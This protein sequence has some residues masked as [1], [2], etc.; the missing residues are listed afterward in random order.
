M[1][2][3]GEWSKRER[4]REREIGGE[5]REWEWVSGG[6]MARKSG[7]RVRVEWSERKTKGE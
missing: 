4:E 7:G 1:R 2:E 5:R 3:G 6:A